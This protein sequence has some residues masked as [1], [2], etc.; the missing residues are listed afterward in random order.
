MYQQM[1]CINFIF[2]STNAMYQLYLGFNKSNFI[3]KLFQTF[4]SKLKALVP[5]TIH[6]TNSL[7]F[8]H[9]LARHALQFGGTIAALV[10]PLVVRAL[11]ALPLELLC[12]LLPAACCLMPAAC[13]L[14]P[15][16]Y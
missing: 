6:P 16:T 11:L 5:Q 3:T 1:Q 9:C 2:D 15:A 10:G 14:L 13:C 7:R 12:C 4:Q 8:L